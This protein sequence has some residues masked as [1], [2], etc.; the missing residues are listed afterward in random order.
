MEIELLAWVM[1]RDG[2][3]RVLLGRRAG[4]ALADGLWNLPGGHV[5]P[6]ES[7]AQAGAREAAEAV[8]VQIAPE[9]L[10]VHGVQRWSVAG[11][12]GFNILLVADRWAGDPT[13]LEGTSEV[14]WFAPD[15][16]PVDILPWLPAVLARPSSG[17]LWWDEVP[18]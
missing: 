16:P 14:G 17:S 1:V 4:T 3:G 13:P 6:R 9:D 12:S 10:T 11:V 5:E 8:G 18:G 2:D 7:V 15:A